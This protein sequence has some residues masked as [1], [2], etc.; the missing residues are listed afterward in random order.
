MWRRWVVAVVF[1]LAAVCSV[2]AGYAWFASAV[3]AELSALRSRIE[4]V[5]S[6]GR[7]VATMTP[8]ERR[9]FDKLMSRER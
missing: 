8:A 2:G 3:T 9:Q 5:D 6:F 7:R 1:A 4:A